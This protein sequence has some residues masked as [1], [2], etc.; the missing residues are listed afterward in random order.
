MENPK[1]PWAWTAHVQNYAEL[2]ERARNNP[3]TSIRGIN[4]RERAKA[5]AERIAFLERTGQ[6]QAAIRLKYGR[7]K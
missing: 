6:K 1:R 3:P 5:R 7:K 2:Y 4:S